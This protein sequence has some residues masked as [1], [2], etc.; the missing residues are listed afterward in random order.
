VGSSVVAVNVAM[1][2]IGSRL[3]RSKLSD[4]ADQPAPRPQRP[5][6]RELL[7]AKVFSGCVRRGAQ[8][9]WSLSVPIRAVGSEGVQRMCTEGSPA[10]LVPDL[11]GTNRTN[12]DSG[13]R[14]TIVARPEG[15]KSTATVWN[16]NS[17]LVLCRPMPNPNRPIRIKQLNE[18]VTSTYRGCG[19]WRCGSG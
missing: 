6:Q 4:D 14:C 2:L 19:W 7:G 1:G 18:R 5:H 3:C 12:R 16:C 15:Y 10:A 8:Q 13:G 11:F 9:L 17:S